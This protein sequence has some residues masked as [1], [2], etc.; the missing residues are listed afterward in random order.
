MYRDAGVMNS[1]KIPRMNPS[2]EQQTRAA[3]LTAGLTL[4]NLC[5][6][7]GPASAQE[8][9]L[10]PAVARALR[11][12][13][14]P[15]TGVSLM[16][17]EVGAKRARLEFNDQQPMNPASLM[18]LV[19]TYAAL[20][21]LGP[22]FTWN[23]SAYLSGN[24]QGDVLDGDLVLKGGGDP[25]L[26]LENLWLFVRNLRAHGL[27]E[28]RGDLVLDRSYFEPAQYDPAQFDAEPL[29]PY[30]VGPD[31]LLVNFKAFRYTFIPDLERRSVS[32]SVEPNPPAL[33][34]GN[35]VK[36]VDGPCG[37][38]K[39]RLRADFQS[40]GN[41]ARATFAGAYPLSCGD[42]TWNVSLLT[43]AA[44]VGSV[45]RQLWEESGGVLHGTVR[46]GNVP[47]NARLLFSAD[48]SQ[49]A[50]I[51]RDINKY[52]NNV[53]ARQ[54]Y[55]TLSAE[56]M[57]QP[58]ATPR[59]AKVI[60]NWLRQHG[61]EFRELSIENG[62]G[63]SR[64]DR[65]SAQHLGNLMLAAFNSP[66]MP[67]LMASLPLVAYDGTMKKRLNDKSVAGQAHVKTG[68]LEGVK[69]IA[70]Y[71]L[72]KNGK[73]DVVVF[74]INHPNA[75]SGQTAQDALLQWV[76]DAAPARGTELD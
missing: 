32:I 1:A 52:S 23:T 39:E 63:L 34:L 13:A 74:M 71:V 53:M 16:V 20:E 72:D 36:G 60:D 69:A 19:T 51:V 62:S 30:N 65:I 14:I 56:I 18:K 21:L 75:A 27:R 12:A 35:S 3:W 41:T 73:L 46:D 40:N 7:P 15:T 9:R 10:P 68:T 50:E 31:A 67:E 55:L 61:F 33:E 6:A 59:S 48:S 43:N 66:V 4:M 26:T 22:A 47:P 45:F 29:R 42:K 8:Q 57:H 49:L 64:S 44:Y 37:D 54:L 76:Y 2:P 24:M 28:V 11:E 38:W 58:G 25:K 70:G 5:M 17:Q